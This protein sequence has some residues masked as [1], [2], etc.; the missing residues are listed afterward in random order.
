[1]TICDCGVSLVDLGPVGLMVSFQD[2]DN[3]LDGGKR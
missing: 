3:F 2:T 1:M